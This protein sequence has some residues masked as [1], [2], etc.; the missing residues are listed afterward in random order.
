MIWLIPFIWIILRKILLTPAPGSYQFNKKKEA[1]GRACSIRMWRTKMK[2]A[3]G[4]LK[5]Q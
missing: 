5:V 2:A 4:R 1:D 3:I